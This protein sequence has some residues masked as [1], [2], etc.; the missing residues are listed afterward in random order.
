MVQTTYVVFAFNLITRRLAARTPADLVRA[1][2]NAAS[3]GSSQGMMCGCP[4][5]ESESAAALPRAACVP[6]WMCVRAPLG[7]RP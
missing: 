1:M 4:N 7:Q 2:G 3:L 5:D 6:W